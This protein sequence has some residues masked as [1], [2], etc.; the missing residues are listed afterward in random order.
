MMKIERL[1]VGERSSGMLLRVNYHDQLV[2]TL[3]LT[4][5][6]KL[7]AFEYAP[8]WLTDGFRMVTGWSNSDIHTTHWI[9]DSRRFALHIAL[10]SHT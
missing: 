1:R 8:S 10:E 4:P 5:D 7:C 6:N 3:S 9:W 2:G